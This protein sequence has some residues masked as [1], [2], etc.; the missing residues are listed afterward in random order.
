[1]GAEEMEG[2]SHTGCALYL[3]PIIPQ[4]CA[5]LAPWGQKA[6]QGRPGEEAIPFLKACLLRYSMGG[7]ELKD[8][9][10]NI[11]LDGNTYE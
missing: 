2:T 10:K 4:P 8:W 5:A 3:L 6:K 11:P 1:M 9:G 7:T